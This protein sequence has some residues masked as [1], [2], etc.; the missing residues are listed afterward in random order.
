MGKHL[1]I[2]ALWGFAAWTWLS[3]AAVLLPVPDIGPIGGFLTAVAIMGRGLTSRQVAQR[4]RHIA[5]SP[6]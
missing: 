3:M 2:A 1:L 6:R 5:D 4:T